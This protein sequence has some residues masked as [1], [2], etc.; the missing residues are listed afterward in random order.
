MCSAT[1]FNPLTW[2][3]PALYL[4]VLHC[5]GWGSKIRDV[6]GV[7]CLGLC[8]VGSGVS[9]AWRV[10]GLG[11]REN[12]C[13]KLFVCQIAMIHLCAWK[14]K[15]LNSLF[16]CGKILCRISH[17]YK[18][19]HQW[20]EILMNLSL[21][22]SLWLA[23]NIQCAEMWSASRQLWDKVIDSRGS[24]C[25]RSS[26]LGTPWLSGRA[27]HSVHCV[28]QH[29]EISVYRI[30]VWWQTAICE[31]VLVDHMSTTRKGKAEMIC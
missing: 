7:F 8:S 19:C 28:G 1:I 5:E 17:S 21:Q 15:A 9:V 3:L 30:W 14:R 25:R 31:A 16:E 20:V 12:W 23:T 29:K 4:L 10:I 18:L 26:P 27:S 22:Q 11:C 13:Q 6:G 24:K 2:T